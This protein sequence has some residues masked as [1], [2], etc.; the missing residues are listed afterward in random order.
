MKKRI[1]I[2]GGTFDPIHIGHLILAEKA[3]E[4]W[5]SMRIW[6]MHFRQTSPQ[7][8]REGQ[9]QVINSGW[10]GCRN[11]IAVKSTFPSFHRRDA[12]GRIYVYL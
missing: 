1:G 5:L 7:Q 6:F 9:C 11:L 8:N 10:R 12:S 4:D 3:Y 2:M